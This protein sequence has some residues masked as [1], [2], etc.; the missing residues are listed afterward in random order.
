[1]SFSTEVACLASLGRHVLETLHTVEDAGCTLGM[2]LLTQHFD[3][4]C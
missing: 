1:M 2:A 3:T 4:H